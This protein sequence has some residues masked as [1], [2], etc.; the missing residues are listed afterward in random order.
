SETVS[1]TEFE[2]FH[3]HGDPTMEVWT[4]MPDNFDV[5]CEILSDS[6]E[7]TV[8]DGSTPVEGALVCALQENGIYVKGLTDEDGQVLLDLIDPSDEYVTLTVTA[9]NYL[10]HHES[11]YLNRAP[12]EPDE[13]EGP[14][15][16]KVG[17]ET[18]YQ[19]R[20]TD[21]EGEQVLYMW[22]WGDGN[23]SSWLGPYTS[24]DTATGSY[25]WMEQGIYFIKVKAKDTND[26]E[27][28]WSDVMAITVPRSKPYITTTFI[29]LLLERFQNSFPLLKQLLEI[30]LTH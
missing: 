9:H 23:Y 25:A 21:P 8:E 6:L 28:D 5:T 10:Y 17:V 18:E 1:R 24:G 15:E 14:R 11:F 30:Y 12:E 19:T 3:V 2:M 22:S 20:T 4:W 26:H 27:S 7:I 13:P 16:I 29:Q